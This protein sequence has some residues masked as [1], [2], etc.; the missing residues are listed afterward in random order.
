MKSTGA[1][2]FGFNEYGMEIA[3]NIQNKYKDVTLFNLDKS[4]FM[5]IQD[6]D[7]TLRMFDLS[8]DWD[9]IEEEFDMDKSII[10][11]AIRD[12]A[13]NIFLT[14]SL[15]SYFKDATIISLANNQENV[16]KLKMAGATKVIPI[17]ETT[18]DIIT[19]MLKKPIATE[20]L[21]KILYED[22]SLKIAQIKITN[23]EYFKDKFPAEIDWS[24]KYGVLVLSIV[25]KDMSKEFIYSSISKHTYLV[26]GDILVVVG[27]DADLQEFKKKIGGC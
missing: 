17:V 22:S 14:I 1:L 4:D 27:Y 24:N 16:N 10:F 9:D 12:E 7:Y 2:I 15:R 8:D 25:H 26:E 5:I 11:C 13:K 3:K 6:V 19:N 20:I 18:A 23:I 21:H